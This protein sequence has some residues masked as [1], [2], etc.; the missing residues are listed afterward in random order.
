MMIVSL[1]NRGYLGEGNGRPACVKS[2]AE[3]RPFNTKKQ[4]E[5]TLERIKKKFPDF[6]VSEAGVTPA[7]KR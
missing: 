2:V 4:A 5:R 3:A 6:D 7:S 1:A